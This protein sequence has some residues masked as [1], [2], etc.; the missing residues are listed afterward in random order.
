M[1][2]GSDYHA[3]QDVLIHSRE[4]KAAVR[5][6]LNANLVG[7]GSSSR[8][9]VLDVGCGDARFAP[10]FPH[11]DW[12]LV[13]PH[14]TPSSPESVIRQDGASFLRE[15]SCQFDHIVSLFSIHHFASPDALND[16]RDVLYPGGSLTIVSVD[17]SSPMFGQ[18][19]WNDL[20]FRDFSPPLHEVSYHQ[21]TDV[22]IPVSCEQLVTW[23]ATKVWSHLRNYSLEDMA[24][25]QCVPAGLASVR[26][27]LRVCVSVR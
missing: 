6:I 8:I 26:L 20:F 4:L 25:L 19:A 5:R 18:A 23:V 22:V 2:A 17:P 14:P 10:E 21:F 11:I 27:R 24:R 1:S 13:D 16:M 9:S 15:C 3:E 12:T 7:T